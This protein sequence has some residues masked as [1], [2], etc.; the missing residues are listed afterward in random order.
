VLTRNLIQITQK[1]F[2]TA[3][4]IN[5][6]P[7]STLFVD[8]SVSLVK[9]I[10]E[11]QQES[12]NLSLLSDLEILLES[13]SRYISQLEVEE[14]TLKIRKT[15]C[16]LLDSIM[17]RKQSISFR[18]ELKFRNILID[19]ILGWTSDFVVTPTCHP[20]INTSKEKKFEET[21]TN[22]SSG[23]TGQTGS[24]SSLA[25][26]LINAPRTLVRTASS[27]VNPPTPVV[28]VDMG[29]IFKELDVEA[30]KAMASLLRGLP[31]NAGEGNDPQAVERKKQRFVKYFSYFTKLLTRCKEEVCVQV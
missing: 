23:V 8:Q 26:G 2:G 4:Q 20:L 5:T 21:G 14:T 19:V 7:K 15:F 31:L 1:F 3:G 22:T 25:T 10:I 9:H 16:T 24:S 12:D 11:L 29:K 27:A 30:M 17:Q 13:L 18:N 28:Q 6:N